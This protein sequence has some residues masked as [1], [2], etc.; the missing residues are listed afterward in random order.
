MTDDDKP[1]FFDLYGQVQE[2][3][4]KDPSPKVAGMWWELARRE[5]SLADFADAAMTHLRTCKFAP[6][7]SELLDLVRTGKWPAPEDAW[8]QAPK[9]EADTAWMCAE[10][11]AALSACQ[12][13]IDRGDMIG[14]R[15]A[16]IETYTAK[17]KTVTGE[18][19]WWISEAS[20]GDWEARQ[21]LKLK[22]LEDKPMRR[23]R[24]THEGAAIAALLGDQRTN[25]GL[26]RV[27]S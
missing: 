7:L 10:T 9:S 20:V 18:P 5:V 11:A 12:D 27:G 4:G 1:A 16:F 14:A 25:K 15:K 19:Q 22:V 8:N 21:Y 23:P 3:Y 17:L 24:L 6:Q 26:V 2:F 13:S